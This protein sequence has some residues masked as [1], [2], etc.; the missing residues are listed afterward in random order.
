MDVHKIDD[1]EFKI[2]LLSGEQTKL[3]LE[4]KNGAL[5]LAITGL[6]LRDKKK[7]YN[8]PVNE[9]EYLKIDDDNNIM[10][11]IGFQSMEVSVFFKDP[12]R[13]K[14]LRDFLLPFISQS[15]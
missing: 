7:W 11:K 10:L 14:G 9:I 13:L 15:S 6:L 5:Y 8:I 4:G 3:Y 1:T 2:E 12:H